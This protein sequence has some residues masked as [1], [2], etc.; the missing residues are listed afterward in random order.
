MESTILILAIINDTIRIAASGG[1]LFLSFFRYCYSPLRIPKAI[2]L[3]FVIGLLTLGLPDFATASNI[4]LNSDTNTATAGYF[5]LSWHSD[6]PV[7][8]FILQESGSEDFTTPVTIYHGT[9]LATVISGKKNSIYF[10]RI[11]AHDNPLN[12][13]NTVR[14]TVA[15]HPLRN[16]FFFF[17]IGAIVF[18]AILLL[19]LHARRQG[20]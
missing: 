1:C 10:Y 3:N 15:H 8:E 14:V 9:D 6:S 11:Y 17:G 5:Q 13:S 12:T 7:K 16:A 4:T 18:V 2:S 20:H 19:I